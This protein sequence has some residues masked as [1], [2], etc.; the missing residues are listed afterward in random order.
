MT[1]IWVTPKFHVSKWSFIVWQTEQRK[2]Y[3][4]AS[5]HTLVR[6][7]ERWSQQVGESFFYEPQMLADDVLTFGVYG[8]QWSDK[9]IDF[10]K[11]VSLSHRM[12]V[13]AQRCARIGYWRTKARPEKG[14]RLWTWNIPTSPHDSSFNLSVFADTASFQDFS[15]QTNQC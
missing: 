3:M 6:T 9:L 2:T 5:L 15:S 10:K 4:K 11:F 7:P 1:Q 13:P 14:I 8:S 12:L